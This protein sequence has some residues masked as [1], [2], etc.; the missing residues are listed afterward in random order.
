[1][2]QKDNK[3][4]LANTRSTADTDSGV[5]EVSVVRNNSGFHRTFT[6]RQIHVISLG[7]QI[8]AGLF[9]STG[10]NLR[11]G[12]AGSLF[13]GFA[14][15]CSCIWAVL[16]TVS[17]MTIAFPTS[18]NFID[19]ADRLVDPA[20]S[21]AAG[22][23]MWIG[24]TAIIASEAT[25]FSVIV[26]YWAQNSVHDGVW[27]TVFLLLMFII[28]SL[29]NAV[30]GWFEYF[31][32]ILKIL[33]LIIFIIVGVALVFGIGPEGTVHHGENWQDGKAFL[34]EFKGF[35]NSVL[36]AILAIGDNTFTG[37]LAGE[38][39][40]PRFSVAHAVFLIPIRVTVFYLI[41]VALIGVLISP[42]NGNLLGSDSGVA[43]SPFVIAI[44]QA[45]I[46]GLPDV[47]NVA[48]IFAVAAIAAESFFIASR[49]L[50]SMAHQG[51]IP[52]W[53]SKVDS[54]GRP[55][56]SLAITSFL[57]VTLTYINLSGEGIT[58]FKWLSQ[59]ASTGYFMVWL[60]ISITS[61]RFRAALRAQNDPLFTET[62]A[63]KCALWPFPPA[64]LFTCCCFYIGTSFYLALYPIGSDTP[65]AY[66]FFQY[67]FGTVLIVFSAIGYKLIFRTKLRDPL[68]VDLQT[69]RRTLGF[70]EMKEL[71][72]YNAMPRWRR[73]VS[74]V[75]LW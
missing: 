74:F 61:F 48:I 35:G 33:V 52:A 24:W 45:G 67:M 23:S 66:Y 75:Q 59:I 9:I 18:G 40:S 4:S 27:L 57:C 29:P 19:Y 34:N 64:W 68:T 44:N 22:F 71:D 26:N 17:E 11:D 58:G 56:I 51:I 42:Y 43:S 25:F 73:F 2:M 20:L 41:S 1:M 8:G 55:R 72:E 16:N 13:L 54:R 60:V 15:V 62:Y 12:G 69:G 5:G 3:D 36:L 65:T 21:F 39:K 38:S 50:Q 6:P 53:V 30:F 49:I 63:W 28:F 7:G 46:E 14:M 47:L 31:T 37:F 10:S 70:E 32:A